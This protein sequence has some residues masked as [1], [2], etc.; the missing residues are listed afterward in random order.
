MSAN[1]HVRPLSLLAVAVFAIVAA[2]SLRAATTGKVTHA[3][4]L[5][6]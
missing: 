4:Q 2:A 1:F 6:P 5:C 3:R